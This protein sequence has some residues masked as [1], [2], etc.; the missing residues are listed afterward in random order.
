MFRNI[1]LYIQI[2]ENMGA[3]NCMAYA[4]GETQWMHPGEKSGQKEQYDGTIKSF[5][6]LT[7]A[8]IQALGYQAAEV[9]YSYVP[10]DGETMIAIRVGPDD[11]HLM[12]RMADG[13]W[14][15]KPGGTC[16]LKL[17]GN[18]WDNKRWEVEGTVNGIEWQSF[19]D[20]YYDSEIKYIKYWQGE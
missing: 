18:P 8:D 16:I 11:F 1:I 15:H 14:T 19:P 7:V 6:D 9:E 5:F 4:L 12:R 3:Y 2:P 20:V 17:N 13:S 10:K